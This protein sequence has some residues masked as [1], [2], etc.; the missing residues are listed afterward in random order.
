M[1]QSTKNVLSQNQWDKMAEIYHRG[2]GRRGDRLHQ[3]Y[4]DPLIFEFLTGVKRADILD[5]GCGNGYLLHGLAKYAKSMVGLDY[6]KRLLDFAKEHTKPLKNVLLL[7]ANLVKNLPLKDNSF[8]VVIANMVLQY[9][10]QLTTFVKEA[11]R[12][13]KRQGLFIVTVDHPGHQLFLRAQELKGHENKK[14][15]DTG[16]YFKPE[17]RLKNSL[18][19]KALLEYFH[20]PIM[21][22]LNPFA[23]L[24]YLERMVENSEDGECPRILGL[25]WIKK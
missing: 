1:K 18:W 23:S 14:F 25:K 8:D 22:Y 20:R 16:S 15:V 9:L 5:A 21:D 17:M 10:P 3:K 7:H 4:I 11:S 12:V 2:I 6:S 13:L 24:F 19:D